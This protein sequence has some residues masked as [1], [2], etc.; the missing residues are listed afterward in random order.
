MDS[1][2]PVRRAAIKLHDEVVS[3]GADPLSPASLIAAAISRLELEAVPLAPDNPTL[4]GARALLD[5][6]TGTICYANDTDAGTS[7]L[8]IAHEA[9]HFC[10]HHASCSCESH[11]IDVTLPTEPARV[12]LQRVEDYGVRERRELQANVFAREFLFPRQLAR[13][14]YLDE[15]LGATVIA[16]RSGLPKD[17]VRQQILDALLIPPPPEEPELKAVA[18]SSPVRSDPSQDD[19]VNHSNSPFQLQAGPGTGKTGT[20]V[21]RVIS[22]INGGV[23]PSTILV[24]TFSNRAAGELADRIGAALPEVA[25][26]IWI[27]TFHSFGL[28]LLRRYHDRLGLPSDPS[29]FDRSDALDVLEEILPTL[30]L[31]HYRNLFDPTLI[32]REFLQAIS[33]A[34]DELADA[35]RYR[36][37][38]QE[39]YDQAGTDADRRKAAEKC[40]E[41]ARVYDLYEKE[42]S[43]RGAVDFGDLVMKPAILLK[44]DTALRSDVQLRHRHVLVDEYQDVNR[45]SGELLRQLAGDGNQVWVVGDSR[46]SIY[47]FRGASSSNMATF[48]TDFP[49]ALVRPLSVNYRS[50]QEIVDTFVAVASHMSASA[51]MLPLKLTAKRGAKGVQPELRGF[52]NADDESE[53]IAASIRELEGAGIRLRDQAILCRSNARLNEIAAALQERGIPA[54]HLGSLFERDEVRDLLALLSLAVDPTCSGMVRVA[55]M[56]GYAFSLQDTYA[57]LGFANEDVTRNPSLGRLGSLSSAPGLSSTAKAS[58]ERLARDLGGLGANASAWEYLATYLLDRSTLLSDLARRESVVDRICGVALWQ[59]L[60]FIREQPL[61]RKGLP[62]QTTLDRVRRLTLLADERDLRQ[63]PAAASHID[64]VRLMTVHASKGLEFD[65]VHIPGLTKASF[66]TTNK[67]QKCPPPVGLIIGAGGSAS[68]D[69]AKHDH[70]QEEQCLFFVAVSRARN[71]LRLY[72]S[73]RQPNG[74][75]RTRSPFVDWIAGPLIKEIAKPARLALPSGAPAPRN[76]E[77]AWPSS[78][79]IEHRR[80]KAYD[81]CALRFFYTHIL[82]IRSARTATPFSRAHDC[83][84]NLIQWLANTRLIA[85]PSAEVF[86]AEVSRIWQEK[87]PIDHA[88]AED[89]KQIVVDL[90]TTLLKAGEGLAFRKAEPLTVSFPSGIVVV[91]PDEIA[92]LPDGQT[93]LRMVQT[94]H[95]RS[96]EYDRPEYTLYMLVGR[97]YYG[98]NFQVRALHL[99]DAIEEPVAITQAKLETRRKNT[100]TTL[101][102]VVAG[103]YPVTLDAVGCPRCPH[104]FICA[105]MPSGPLNLGE[106][107]R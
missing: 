76:L 36:E 2:E 60:N 62:I 3:L 63:I 74:N 32:L 4:K 35:A 101:A 40:L 52:E 69:I 46:Q 51:K 29:L 99:T 37:L 72:Y 93:M 64:A 17:L 28:D 65:A 6:Q 96:D 30:R 26:Q 102:N 7:A 103:K 19:A 53:G 22:L 88:Y 58:I 45:A 9:G 84:Y 24:L 81:K 23:E 71:H 16:T 79:T 55:T 95:K 90:G 89:Y 11:D 67:G 70:E 43:K 105:A 75:N 27:G 94:G 50:S 18:A 12:G 21:R 106:E 56:P 107:N 85:P 77:V 8:V 10:V 39:M 87:G 97:A 42:L 31:Q 41:V 33:R 15:G 54:L 98:E 1:F 83:L 100:E 47:R 68:A 104:F 48:E 38:G 57:L 34:K 44:K 5:W 91:E 13:R 92:S 25:P 49:G 61:S 59:F 82:R 80:L 20:L 66:P 86:L 14:L 78:W 73:R